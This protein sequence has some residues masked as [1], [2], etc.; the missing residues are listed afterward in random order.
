MAKAKVPCKG[1]LRAT[2]LWIIGVVL[3]PGQPT[4]E[5]LRSIISDIAAGHYDQTRQSIQAALSQFPQ[6]PRL[7]TLDSLA[8]ARSGQTREALPCMIAL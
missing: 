1:A 7:W 6:D 5:P 2:A 3:A 4:P 8:L